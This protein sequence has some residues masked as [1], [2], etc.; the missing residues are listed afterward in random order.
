MNLVIDCFKLVKGAGKS[1][2]IYNLTKSLVEYLGAENVRR[3]YA[4]TIL[5][6]GNTH[7]RAD[8]EVDG[9]T[10]LLMKGNPLDRKYDLWWE[11]FGVKHAAGKY[12]ADR[13][14]FPRGFR[15]LVYHG[16]DT[17]IIHDLIPFYY[18][19]H[20]PGVFNRYENAYIMNRLKASIKGADRIITIS[21][22]S[23]Q[24]IARRVPGTEGKIARIYNGLNDIE[25]VDLTAAVKPAADTPDAGALQGQK[26][27]GYIIAVT[28]KLPHKNA[29]GI[30]KAYESYYRS[31]VHPLR[32]VIIGIPDIAA[33][34]AAGIISAEAAAHVEC[35]GYVADY[36]DMCRM[37]HGAVFFLFLSYAEGFGFPPLEAMQ[38][39]CPVICSD[40][41]SLAEV[42][43]DAG[44]LVDPDEA[45]AV[46]QAMCRLQEDPQL[47]A[48]LVAK[49]TENI[50][51]FSWSSRIPLYWEELFRES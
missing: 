28:S 8:M 25:G 50:R 27:G 44:I 30:L 10:F 35:H 9:V 49:G 13:I 2:G 20:F 24:D 22:Y 6:L 1:I 38:L 33:Q 12:H 47:R 41:T 26:D 46:S 40:R 43:G 29:P 42:V 19:E 48:D 11:L 3:N 15:P 39:Q 4:Q 51:R 18:D 32:L 21:D 5:I 17:I 7:N 36:G 23:M 31:A 14:L 16:K 34:T 37:I 45:G